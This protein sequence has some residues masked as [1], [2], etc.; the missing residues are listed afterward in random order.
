MFHSNITFGE[1]RPSTRKR[2]VPSVRMQIDKLFVELCVAHCCFCQPYSCELFP[3]PG[4]CGEH[5][6]Q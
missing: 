6:L 2:G 1:P 3:N 5:G 4:D